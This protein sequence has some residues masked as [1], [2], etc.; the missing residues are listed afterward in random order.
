M[1]YCTRLQRFQV[2]IQQEEKDI[3]NSDGED[4]VN[5]RNNTWN[6]SELSVPPQSTPVPLSQKRSRGRPTKLDE[7]RLNKKKHESK[8]DW[9]DE[10]VRERITV[11]KEEEVHLQFKA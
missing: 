1:F 4:S 3:W 5:M 9:R 8:R 2:Q 11:W 7:L 10:K 6:Q